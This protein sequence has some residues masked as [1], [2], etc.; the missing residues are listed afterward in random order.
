MHPFA[1]QNFIEQLEKHLRFVL[2]DN[3]SCISIDNLNI[4]ELVDILILFAFMVS[5]LGSTKFS[6]NSY[7]FDKAKAI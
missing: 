5:N 2:A 7:L 1:L 3:S 6:E 4:K